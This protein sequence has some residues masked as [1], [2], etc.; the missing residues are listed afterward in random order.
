VASVKR[1]LSEH[2]NF[3]QQ[4]AEIAGQYNADEHQI[5]D[6]LNG[7]VWAMSTN[8]EGF[9]KVPGLDMRVGFAFGRHP[10]PALKV[11]FRIVDENSV[12]LLWVEEDEGG[13]FYE[14]Y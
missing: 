10:I 2:P 11:Y 13:H 3:R 14:A 5:D 7:L 6:V 8:A 9:R 12:E 4:C 1:E